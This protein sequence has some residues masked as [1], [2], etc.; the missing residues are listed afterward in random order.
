M[1]SKLEDFKVYN[2]SMEVGE[3]VWNVVSGWGYFEKDTVGKQRV[4]AVDSIAANLSEG[5]GRYHF[6]ETKNFAYYSRGSLFETKTWLTKAVN[7]KLIKEEQF[8]NIISR[9]KE[10]GKMIN[11]YIK[12]IGGVNEPFA[13]YDINTEPLIPNT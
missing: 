7:R 9:I 8:L 5:L 11:C 6:K 3:E 12:S 13:N 1:I 2:L 4:R 10:I